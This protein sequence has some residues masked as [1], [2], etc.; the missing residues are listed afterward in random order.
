[1]ADDTENQ[2][3]IESTDI[4][5]HDL[6]DAPLSDFPDRPSLPALALF[7]GKLI[8]VTA[9]KSSQ[10]KTPFLRFNVRLT[11]AGRDV[12]ASRMKA[13]ADAG[14]SLSDY[15][16]WGEFYLT[17]AAMPML[18]TFMETLG[19][20][21]S[22]STKEQLK[23]NENYAPT[24]ESQDAIRGLDVICTTQEAGDNGRVFGRLA[25]I[26]GTAKKAGAR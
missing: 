15:E 23:L 21:T 7:K 9:G 24:D 10:K 19:F 12:P 20:S 3:E 17:K 16:T 22:M 26:T 13:I 2:A 6:L 8:G 4:D 11:E 18:R 14:F 25:N 1:M 5:F